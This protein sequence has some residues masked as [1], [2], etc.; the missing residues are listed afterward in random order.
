MTAT[1][2]FRRD[3]VMQVRVYAYSGSNS[4]PS[5]G[6][7]YLVNNVETEIESIVA[8]L[9]ASFAKLSTLLLPPLLL[10]RGG[11]R[12]L[13]EMKYNAVRET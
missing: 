11:F 10:R 3:S 4:G 7:W 12:C 1:S 5:S 13:N 6:L 8:A 9:V 2:A